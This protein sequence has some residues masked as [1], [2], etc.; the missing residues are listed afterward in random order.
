MKNNKNYHFFAAHTVFENSYSSRANCAREK[1]DKRDK[2][3][4]NCR[5]SYN[6]NPVYYS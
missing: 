3:L 6:Q 2:K 1:E 5:I 4:F